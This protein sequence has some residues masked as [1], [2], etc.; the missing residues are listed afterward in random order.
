[1]FFATFVAEKPALMLDAAILFLASLVTWSVV[2]VYINI[3][4]NLKEIRKN[5]DK[6]KRE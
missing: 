6:S 5:T 2:K 3:S 4:C 1:M